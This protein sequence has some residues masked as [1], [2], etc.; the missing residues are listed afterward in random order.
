MAEK[1]C[2]ICSKI[3][4]SN[5]AMYCR[6]CSSLITRLRKMESHH[7]SR[8]KKLNVESTFT[9]VEWLEMLK[10]SSYSCMCCGIVGSVAR[11]R[12][13]KI[14]IP[15]HVVSLGQGGTNTAKN[16]QVLCIGCN[17]RK[18]D[19]TIDYRPD[20]FRLKFMSF[21]LERELNTNDLWRFIPDP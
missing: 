2:V 19:K 6:N 12:Q 18:S 11:C 8:A 7:K 17:T 13:K 15:D 21:K 10:D 1:L 20:E 4:I 5:M 16:I 9:A 14:L 3:E